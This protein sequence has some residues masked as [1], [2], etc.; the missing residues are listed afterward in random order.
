MVPIY[1]AERAEQRE[2]GMSK[3]MM[4]SKVRRRVRE[5][6]N[7]RCCEGGVMAGVRQKYIGRRGV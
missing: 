5:E 1:P 2:G 4:G 3:K 7:D 6:G